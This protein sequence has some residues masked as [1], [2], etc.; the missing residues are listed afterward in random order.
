MIW[1]SA[2]AIHPTG[3]LPLFLYGK[4]PSQLKFK[5]YF[6]NIWK[7]TPYNPKLHINP[8]TK[9]IKFYLFTPIQILHQF[10]NF[11]PNPRI[12]KHF[13]SDLFLPH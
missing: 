10:Q 8:Y 1:V 5:L 7:Y 3:K 4:I 2:L 9:V 11:N 13:A 6:F 12:E